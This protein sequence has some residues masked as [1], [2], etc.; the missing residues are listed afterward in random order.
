MLFNSDPTKS[1]QKVIV[2]RKK[3]DSAHPNTFFN[4][5]PVERASQQKH[6]WIH[7]D[8]KLNLKIYILTVLSKVNKG[9]SII[10]K[11]MPN[12]PRKSLL[13]IYKAFLRPHIDYSN[14][15]Y[16]QPSNESFCERY[17]KRKEISEVAIQRCS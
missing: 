15:I 2:S 10:K 13:T 17:I 11:L 4:I 6:L 7:I 14:V 12:L 16:D 9:I 8:E 3:Y 1:A 5:I